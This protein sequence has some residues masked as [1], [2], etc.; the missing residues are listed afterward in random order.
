M[1]L[2]RGV[3]LPDDEGRAAG[4]VVGAGDAGGEG[5]MDNVLALLAEGAEII[6]ILGDIDLRGLG[7]GPFGHAA[8]KLLGGHGGAQIV[9][10]EHIVHHV[11][12]A[13]VFDVDAVKMLLAQI[14][15]GAAAEDII[16]HGS[17]SFR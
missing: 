14:G 6:H 12:E 4:G 2:T 17:V 16:S 13:D 7:H 1:D 10:I 11:V 3:A 15:G 8:V 5:H 9:G